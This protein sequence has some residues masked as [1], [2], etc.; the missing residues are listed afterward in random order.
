[1][2]ISLLI[3]HFKFSKVLLRNTHTLAH[4]M[5]NSP[6]HFT[7]LNELINFKCVSSQSVVIHSSPARYDL[8]KN[9]QTW[10]YINPWSKVS[11]DLQQSWIH[12]K[13]NNGWITQVRRHN[14]Y[15]LGN[16]L[17]CSTE[18]LHWENFSYLENLLL[19]KTHRNIIVIL[20]GLFLCIFH[21]IPE[22]IHCNY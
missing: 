11:Q 13:G 6:T 21:F 8:F 16:M 5:K 22:R 12:A 2:L 14:S 1:M 17:H 9:I 15:L 7:S 4:S 19:L 3:Q 20:F 10:T 18:Q